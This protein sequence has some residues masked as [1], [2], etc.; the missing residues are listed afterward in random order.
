M[1][2]KK[3]KGILGIGALV[4][5]ST[6][7]ILSGCSQPTD[8]T[9]TNIEQI[10]SLS[11]PVVKVSVYPGVNL[12]SW[13]YV[14]D[15][16]SYQVTRKDS[17]GIT[18]ILADS[19][20]SLTAT[21][22]FVYF[23]KVGYNNQ[24]K[25]QENYTYT[26]IAIPLKIFTSLSSNNG[27]GS[28]PA[29]AK[30]PAWNDETAVN[31]V[32]VPAEADVIIRRA[33][34]TGDYLEVIWQDPVVDP[35]T[36]DAATAVG[37]NYNV[38]YVYGA[39]GESLLYTVAGDYGRNL[40]VS[41]PGVADIAGNTYAPVTPIR[42]V[43]F[44]L[45]G[46]TPKIEIYG[47]R[48][49]DNYY[50]AKTVPKTGDA[51]T[52]TVLGVVQTFNATRGGA[53][54]AALV[55]LTWTGLTGATGYDVY[56]TET[57]GVTTWEAI[58]VSP[59]L[60]DASLTSY[61]AIDTTAAIDKAYKYAIV[62]K[63]DGARSNA[64]AFVTVSANAILTATALNTPA[65]NAKDK[66]IA[67]SWT[68]TD[69]VTYKLERAIIE[70]PVSGTWVESGYEDVLVGTNI[71]NGVQTVVDSTVAYWTSYRYRLLSTLNGRTLTSTVQ[72]VTTDPFNKTVSLNLSLT[73]STDTVYAIDV[74][75]TRTNAASIYDGLTVT[76]YRAAANSAGDNIIGEWTQVAEG[77]AFTQATPAATAEF[78]YT[79]GGLTPD[80]RYFY[81]ADVYAGTT[82]LKNNSNLTPTAS[83][84]PST[85]WIRLNVNGAVTLY[86]ST[87]NSA[88]SL[89]VA[90]SSAALK[91]QYPILKGAKLYVFGATGAPTVLGTIQYR[92][93]TVTVQ[94]A[95]V[96]QVNAYSYF[97]PVSIGTLRTLGVSDYTLVTESAGANGVPTAVA[98][99]TT[100][101]INAS[102]YSELNG[103]GN[104]VRSGDNETAAA[105]TFGS[106]TN[107]L[108]P[109][110][111]IY[112]Q[113]TAGE[114]KLV[115]SV[116]RAAAAGRAGTATVPGIG[117][118]V[119][120][121]DINS[122]LWTGT[123]RDKGATT[124]Y[125]RNLA[126]VPVAGGPAYTSIG[127]PNF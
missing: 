19:I 126:A 123:L 111:S 26:V 46:G 98:G 76:L 83:I 80:V 101:A 47:Y 45:L 110:T 13:D 4:L 109:G 68:V 72:D 69:G 39:L 79:D 67:L 49:E 56:R 92:D 30:I 93:A 51:V 44:P 28:V 84:Y 70:E 82:L 113:D 36:P 31:P 81:R 77:L 119:Y 89:E 37:T 34:T 25:D 104:V 94:T 117:G 73:Q 118:D 65:V 9:N 75:G 121:F 114:Y 62:A 53:T 54:N 41:S 7:L 43:I 71:V 58:T 100:A 27:M 23:D 35:K 86:Y 29:V 96:A 10:P 50:A 21:T 78:E 22:T 57:N 32:W 125:I 63:A 24:L 11:N 124:L 85:A 48:D 74:T 88:A 12:L 5:V 90:L 14:K 61:S 127:S 105:V 102:V 3:F 107:T 112:Y 38:K 95:T 91:D 97:V 120:F 16:G 40:N 33:D 8:F 108:I 60:T 66:T 52:A 115:G 15:A 17:N 20:S 116:T 106:A 18:T 6:V 42:R 87:D 59:I 2:K 122:V 99:K 55:T 1:N 64:P 103:A